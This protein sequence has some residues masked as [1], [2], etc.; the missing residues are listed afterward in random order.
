MLRG[1]PRRCR[2]RP[3]Q[4]NA[5]QPRFQ[6]GGEGVAEGQQ[7]AADDARPG[8][9]TAG[10]CDR[11]CRGCLEWRHVMGPEAQC[12]TIAWFTC[13][14]TLVP[15]RV[16][17]TQPLLSQSRM[18]FMPVCAPPQKASFRNACQRSLLGPTYVGPMLK[19]GFQTPWNSIARPPTAVPAPIAG[20]GSSATDLSDI[21]SLWKD[22][23]F[24]HGIAVSLAHRS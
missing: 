14:R 22:Q 11:Q 13:Y 3:C 6:V 12:W 15:R 20:Q 18:H 9:R 4:G 17:W 7:R 10:G 5:L 8:P 24:T 16:A 23:A 21:C 19:S 1:S 2:W